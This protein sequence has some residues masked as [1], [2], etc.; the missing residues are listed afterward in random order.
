MHK[1]YNTRLF[2]INVDLSTYVKLAVIYHMHKSFT[3]SYANKLI[4]TSE[5]YK[6]NLMKLFKEKTDLSESKIKDFLEK[7]DY[8][9]TA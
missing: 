5:D 1:Y 2:G 9:L 8:Y 7:A 4:V 6:S 3:D